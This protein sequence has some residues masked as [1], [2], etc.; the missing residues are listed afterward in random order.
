[1]NQNQHNT[2]QRIK[3]RILSRKNII[4]AKVGLPLQHK[5][6]LKYNTLYVKY[7]E[8][9]EPIPQSI[10]AVPFITPLLF[11]SLA[12]G[13]PI[14]VE[15][16]DEEFLKSIRRL[17][18]II[19]RLNGINEPKT[20]VIYQQLSKNTHSNLS[21]KYLI[22]YGG[23]ID[24]SATLIENLKHKP[25]LFTVQGLDISPEETKAW[26]YKRKMIRRLAQK[27]K[28]Q[29]VFA[30]TNIKEAIDTHHLAEKYRTRNFWGEIAHGPVTIC[31]SAPITYK[32]NVRYVLSPSSHGED[33]YFKWGSSRLIDESVSWLKTR[34]IHSNYKLS[35]QEKII[36]Y[37]KNN[38]WILPYLQ[39]CHDQ[40][41]YPNCGLCEKCLRTIAGL[42]LAGV[43]PRK[44]HFGYI[45]KKTFKML[46]EGF[47]KGGLRWTLKSFD[48]NI[49]YMWNDIKLHIKDDIPDIMGSKYFFISLKKFNLE[50]Y[51]P[52]PISQ[53]VWRI[54]Y[55]IIFK[56]LKT[57]LI[58]KIKTLI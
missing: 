17:K 55:S 44:M 14:E 36:K 30:E 26:H 37:I 6:F 54:S 50:K 41:F 32:Y 34:V 39:V 31:L 45:G 25:I 1:M 18:K 49:R 19:S 20:V 43:D 5:K 11:L 24:S 4:I 48:E 16:I 40:Y 22:L 9:I 28:L 2:K 10:A 58:R 13:I 33:R 8:N 42:A 12:T 47:L 27:L 38:Q 46:E 23:G 51:R 52:N 3:L 56:K 57:E 53:L 7:S 15:V 35:R 21:N 29:A